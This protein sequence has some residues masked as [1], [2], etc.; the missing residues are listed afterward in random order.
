MLP[1]AV[2]IRISVYDEVE[3]S[4][5]IVDNHDLFRKQ[6]QDVWCLEQV[7]LVVGSKAF[8][9]IFDGLVAKTADQ[10]AEKAR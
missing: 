7:G 3:L 8:L 4:R 10:P 6:Q 2:L 9:N 1:G 5:E